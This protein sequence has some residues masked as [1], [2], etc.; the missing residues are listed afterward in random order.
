MEVSDESRHVLQN[1]IFFLTEAVWG[2]A[3][4]ALCHA[5]SPPGG[6][7]PHAHIPARLSAK[8]FKCV[9]IPCTAMQA[10]LQ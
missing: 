8:L 2:S 4:L 5:H 1:D 7:K 9:V 6:V 10:M 3:S